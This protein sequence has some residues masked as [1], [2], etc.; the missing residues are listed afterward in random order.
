MEIVILTTIICVLFSL[1][2]FGPMLYAHKQ[3]KK[4]GLPMSKKKILKR[5]NQKL[6]DIDRTL[7]DMESDGIYFSPFVK[8]EL[9]KQR[10]E[11]HCNYSDLPSVKSYDKK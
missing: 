9:T 7:S 8:E 5:I 1:F 3:V 4:K 2:I 10:E 11:L 6:S